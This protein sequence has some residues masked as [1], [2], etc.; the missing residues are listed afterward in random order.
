MFIIPVIIKTIQTNDDIT[1][2]QVW[3]FLERNGTECITVDSLKTANEFIKVNDIP[4]TG[5]LIVSEPYIYAPVDSNAD[6][7][8]FYLWNEIQQHEQPMKEVWRSFLWIVGNNSEDDMW[9]TNVFLKDI[10]IGGNHSVYNVI[11]GYFKKC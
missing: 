2:K 9:G 3:L 10:L 4:V 1:I 11:E 5:K 6:L 8:S 7:S